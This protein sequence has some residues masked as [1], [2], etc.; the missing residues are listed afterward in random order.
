MGE[1][2]GRIVEVEAYEGRRDPASHAYGRVTGRN[3]VMHGP[4]GRLYVYRSYGVHWCANVVC[5]PGDEAGA[6]LIR[7]IEPL[8]GIDAMWGD[9]PKA[10]RPTDLG[11]GPGKTCAALGITG[12]HYGVDL[13]AADAP[14][15]LEP[16]STPERDSVAVGTRVGI[17]R[18]AERPWRFAIAGN[19]H[20][21]RPRP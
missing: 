15:R 20:V 8:S 4:P 14:I 10:R 21:S 19:A 9:R 17:T 13:L 3:R 6:L 12:E 18:A 11:S 16:G 7:A 2:R 1:R 5:H